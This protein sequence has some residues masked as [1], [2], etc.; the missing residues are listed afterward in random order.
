M[1][2]YLHSTAIEDLDDPVESVYEEET[3]N[4]QPENTISPNKTRNE[5]ASKKSESWFS[6]LLSED[7]FLFLAL[8]VISQLEFK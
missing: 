1:T 8:L 7:N 5:S 6:E 2:R 3:E 4:F